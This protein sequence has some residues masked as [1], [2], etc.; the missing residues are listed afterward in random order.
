MTAIRVQVFSV[1]KA[2]N[3]PEEYEDAIAFDEGSS[4]VAITDG[5]SDA[6]EAGKW[7][8]ALVECYV[9]RPPTF[10]AESILSWLVAPIQMWRAG[11]Q[12]ERLAWYA[13]EK[14][15]RGSFATLLGINF[16][17]IHPHDLLQ[18]NWSWSAVALGDSCLFHLRAN[19]LLTSFPC[20]RHEEF[21]T[22]PWLVSTNLEYSRQSLKGLRTATGEWRS[23]DLML[24][25]T[26]ALA[27]WLLNRNGRGVDF[28]RRLESLADGDFLLLVEQARDRGEMRNDDVTLA[29]IR[30]CGPKG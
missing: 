17:S 11:I 13:E 27:A 6:F 4:R 30:F 3:Q 20:V 18:N 28:W 7:A 10:D 24:V 8:R 12:W 1:P 5:A 29:V 2:G 23:G 19:V 9:K 16:E 14:A 22:T 15:R 25:S 26:D 21:D